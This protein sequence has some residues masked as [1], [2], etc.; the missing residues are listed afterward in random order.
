MANLPVERP[1]ITFL[2]S[3]TGAGHRAA[4]EAIIEAL[5]CEYGDKII[6]QMVDFLNEYAPFPFSLLPEAYPA[7]AGNEAFWTTM[8]ESSNGR[9]GVK[10]VTST[11]WPM[12]RKAA[13]RLL[14]EVTSDVIV[15]VHPLATTFG[16]KAL[17]D[18]HLPFITVVTD[19]VSGHALWFNPRSDL[20]IVPTEMARQ[21]AL[22]YSL[23]AEKVRLLG[24]PILMRCD[25]LPHDKSVL[26]QRLGWP[27]QKFTAL[28][29][30]G[31]EGMGPL[32][33]TACAIDDSDL[34]I[35]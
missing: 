18:V 12:V 22:S 33:E 13:Y 5:H 14:D 15:S 34:D 25:D 21:L 17:G 8:F 26:R 28:L 4:S 10:L 16:L 20:T 11:I 6:T 1:R 35:S 2:F 23:P 32:M 9:S 27:Q 31:G 3:D 30:G 24:L 7:M 19:L 29:V